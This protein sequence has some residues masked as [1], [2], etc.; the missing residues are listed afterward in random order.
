MG[1]TDFLNPRATSN[2]R[3]RVLRFKS[4]NPASA[5]MHLRSHQ[6]GDFIGLLGCDRHIIQLKHFIRLPQVTAA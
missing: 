6:Q 1:N 2:A 3:K 4:T 5:L